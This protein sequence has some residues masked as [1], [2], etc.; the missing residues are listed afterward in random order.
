MNNLALEQKNNRLLYR[1]LFKKAQY[2][3]KQQLDDVKNIYFCKNNKNCC[4]LRYSDLSPVEVYEASLNGD[5]DSCEFMKLFVPYGA[6]FDFVYGKENNIDI[7]LNHSFAQNVDSGYVKLINEKIKTD[8][9]FY[10][11]KNLT[12]ENT[13]T[14]NES[15]CFVKN[16]FA[17]DLLTV[18]PEGCGYRQW[19]KL[20]LDKI[21]NIIIKDIKDKIAEISSEREKF[22]C[23]KTGTCCRLACSKFGYEELKQKAQSGDDYARQFVSVF[24]PYPNIDEPEVIF[25]DYVQ[26]VHRSL[27]KDEKLYFYH[28]PH[29]SNDNLCTI[30]ENRP[31]ICRDFPHDVL[32]ILPYNCGY[33]HW[34]ES[35][36]TTAMLLY[37]M[38]EIAEYY[39]KSLETLLV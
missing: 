17:Q 11:C 29:V 39:K 13:C 1:K 6:D 37:A 12:K 7:S 34:K 4:K 27:D 24:V 19:Q 32:A 31:Q 23:K 10:Y 26:L 36:E 21:E 28:C 9:Y 22:H 35:C 15:V 30:Y 2:S 5:F 33:Y 8:K 14:K 3:I 20:A 18:F 38:I 16:N 25:P